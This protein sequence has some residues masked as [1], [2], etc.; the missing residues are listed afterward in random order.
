[1]CYIGYSSSSGGYS[2]DHNFPKLEF[3]QTSKF[4]NHYKVPGLPDGNG[5]TMYDAIL[6]PSLKIDEML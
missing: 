3:G 2:H 4:T 1:M 5:Y 6:C